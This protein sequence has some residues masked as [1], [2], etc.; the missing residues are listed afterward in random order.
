MFK[1]TPAIAANFIFD[2]NKAVIEVPAPNIYTTGDNAAVS[3]ISLST[4]I[5]E[6][7]S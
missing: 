1:T 2:F 3:S 7:N 6:L 4:A 5:I